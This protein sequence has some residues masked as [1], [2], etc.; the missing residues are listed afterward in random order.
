MNALTDEPF[1]YRG[2]S[3]VCSVESTA[4]GLFMPHV[5]YKYGIQN[6]ERFTLPDDTE[7]Y[8]S[9]AEAHRHAQ[10]Q[11]MRWVHDRTGD[12]RGQF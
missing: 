7:P 5:L 1:E 9:A 3:F 4:N 11:A 6:L 8:A 10:Q 12:G 2:C